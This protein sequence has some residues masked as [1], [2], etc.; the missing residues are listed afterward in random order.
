M[1]KTLLWASALV[2]A[3]P[4]TG[5]LSPE[6]MAKHEAEKQAEWAKLNGKWKVVARDGDIDA[7]LTRAGFYY[8]IENE[9]MRGVTIAKD[10]KEEVIGRQRLRI[11]WIK[12]P[13]TIDLVSVDEN[14]KPNTATRT[15]NAGERKTTSE[16]KDV[17]VYKV[18]GDT[19]T[20]CASHDENRPA[21]FFVN[22]RPFWYLLKLERV[23]DAAKEEEPKK[24]E[25]KK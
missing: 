14:G 13:K 12:D 20:I 21:E 18:E 15:E 3:V 22:A 9:V 7:D 5:C 23:K 16:V 10:G 19:L 17:G 4:F 8:V 2:L 24:D 11:T 6:E 1:R 25:G